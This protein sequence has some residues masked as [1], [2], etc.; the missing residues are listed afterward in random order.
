VATSKK[1]V[2]AGNPGS[3]P[4][5][6]DQLN[7]S[8]WYDWSPNQS[9][10]GAGYTGSA[11]YVPEFWSTSSSE[12]LPL[13]V[14]PA[15]KKSPWVFTFDDPDQSSQSDLTVNEAIQAWPTVEAD[16]DSKLIG[17]PDIASYEDGWLT[18]FLNS[19]SANGYTVNFLVLH[20]YP[21]GY[22]TS[23]ATQVSTFE[24][25]IVSVHN[26]HPNYQ[27]VV[28]EFAL[29]NTNGFNGNGIT[30]SEQIAFINQI[31]PWLEAQ[32][33][34]LG[35]SWYDSYSGGTGSDLLNGDG[36]LTP[37]GI[38]YS[39]SGCI[40]NSTTPVPTLHVRRYVQNQ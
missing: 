32:S 33:Y 4:N 31:V 30:A 37:I 3:N 26:A 21:N 2:A 15:A 5:G 20:E 10:Y 25:Y 34:I 11:V 40:G 38:A 39:T 16:S 14:V 36:T 35:Y 24:N 9:L 22:G 18:N 8:W 28:N 23:L 12:L 17:A 7:V 6:L 1:G 19:A 29:V 27:I 13:S